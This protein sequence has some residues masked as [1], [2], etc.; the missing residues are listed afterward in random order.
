MKTAFDCNNQP[1]FV[2]TVISFGCIA[3]PDLIQFDK[4]QLKNKT[5]KNCMNT[6][7]DDDKEHT[8][9]SFL[10]GTQFIERNYTSH[11]IIRVEY[12]R[13]SFVFSL[14]LEERFWLC[15]IGKTFKSA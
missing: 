7:D 8:Y 1:T 15:N 13:K 11:V 9:Y 10:S 5:N 2:M 3:G 12:F 4:G 6:Q 14:K